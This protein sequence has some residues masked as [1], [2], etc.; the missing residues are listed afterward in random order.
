MQRPL[1][2]ITDSELMLSEIRNQYWHLRALRPWEQAKR[3]KL[4]RKI[5]K[6]KAVLIADGLDKELLRLWC[7]Q[8]TR[9]HAE[10]S[11]VR[12]ATYLQKNH[13]KMKLFSKI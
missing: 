9:S 2:F 10:A 4:Y 8:F 1:P 3:R 13:P 12:F 6:I 11:S 5:T 7:R